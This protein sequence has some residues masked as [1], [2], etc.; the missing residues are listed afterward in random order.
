MK[1]PASAKYRADWHL[2][3]ADAEGHTW[4]DDSIQIILLQEIRD[5]LQRLN[6]LLSCPNFV[7]IP[8]VLRAIRANTARPRRR[9]SPAKKQ[10]EPQP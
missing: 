3:S 6:A 7:Q 9:R 5:E 8:Q 10:K 2:Y 1:L 4:Q